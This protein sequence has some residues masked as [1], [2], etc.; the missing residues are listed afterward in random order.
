MLHQRK[1][2]D[3][4]DI[5]FR[6]VKAFTAA[7]ANCLIVTVGKQLTVQAID[8]NLPTVQHLLCFNHILRKAK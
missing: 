3:T 1:T 7:T 5:F 2:A 4:H 8:S 6:H